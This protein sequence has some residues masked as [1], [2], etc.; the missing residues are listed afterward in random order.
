[1][2][3]LPEVE[4][5]RRGLATRILHK[6]ITDVKV[7]H[8][9]TIRTPMASFCSALSGKAF[10]AVDRRGK[11]LILTVKPKAVYVLT[12]LKMTGQLIYHSDTERIA[13]GH[14]WPPVDDG[15]PNAYT[16]V[17]ITFSDGSKLYFNDMRRFGYW[18]VVDEAGLQKALAAYGPEPL[19][20][21]FTYAV[22][23]E[24]MKGRAVSVKAVLLDQRV[25]AGIGNIYA[26]EICFAAGVNPGRRVSRLT[27]DEHAKM[28]RAIRRILRL[29][30]EYGGT[31]FRHYR[32]AGGKKGNYV[33]LLKVYGRAGQQ[34]AR[35]G[36]AELKKT[37]VA[38]RGTVY[39]PACQK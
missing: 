27:P 25:I 30:I 5:I 14:N 7:R 32:D 13:G 16:H 31:T 36:Q 10:Q 20:P 1:M 23:R 9:K 38:G 39:C 28:Y 19:A 12:H 2:P 29:A 15:V 8:A 34:C 37:K 17:T 6:K 22:Y 21:R 4:T 35:C 33:R 3:E 18:Q 11:L 24:R 26:D